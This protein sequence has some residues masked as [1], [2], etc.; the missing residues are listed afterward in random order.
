[1][2]NC[3]DL[4]PRQALHAKTLEFDHPISGERLKFDSEL[5][6]DIYSVIEKWRN[7]VKLK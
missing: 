1:M 3:F 6:N 7:Y 5:P 4:L 2:E